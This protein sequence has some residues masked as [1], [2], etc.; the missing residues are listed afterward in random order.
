MDRFMAR[1]GW[2]GP[3][4]NRRGSLFACKIRLDRDDSTV[5]CTDV[6]PGWAARLK[7]GGKV[8]VGHGAQNAGEGPASRVSA[9]SQPLAVSP[10]LEAPVSLPL[11]LRGVSSFA[12]AAVARQMEGELRRR[13]A[14]MELRD[15]LA[16]HDFSGWRY[17]R[18]EEELARYG[19]SVLRAWMY[20]GYVFELTA[21]RGFSLRPSAAE[22]EELH[23]DPD[24]REELA[25]MT[26]ALALPRFRERALMGGGWQPDGGAGLPTYF[27]GACLYV[28]PNQF[29]SR[30]VQTER[31]R[32]Q[33]AGDPVLAMA[34][35]D[36]AGDPAVLTVGR[37]WILGQLGDLD[38]RTRAIVTLTILGFHQDE[39][40]EMLAE[41]SVRAVEGVLYRWRTRQK[42]LMQGGDQ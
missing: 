23:R 18:F 8:A 13:T 34:D 14:D 26:V 28:F 2:H 9:S 11:V 32:R 31:W 25:N 38:P 37:L 40:A 5:V 20:S 3:P 15:K 30:R 33:N 27:M 6:M 1:H 12:D 36:P 42:K 29:R 17:Q 41:P 39:I 16:A 35:E 19:I 7:S 21:S 22:L 24:A 10:G 4:P